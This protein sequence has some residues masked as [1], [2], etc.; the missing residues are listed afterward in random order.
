MCSDKENLKHTKIYTGSLTIELYQVPPHT[1][2][3]F[4]KSP[5][6]FYKKNNKNSSWT[7]QKPTTQCKTLL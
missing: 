3:E 7:L 2:M 5:K 1:K 6:F 4:T